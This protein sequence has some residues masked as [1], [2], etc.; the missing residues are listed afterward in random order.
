LQVLDRNY[1]TVPADQTEPGAVLPQKHPLVQYYAAFCKQKLGEGSARDWQAGSELSPSLVFP[2]SKTDRVVLE[3][4]LAANQSDATAHYLLGMLLFSKGLTDDGVAHWTEAKQLAPHLPV[5]DVEMGNFFL[6]LKGDPQR[7]L[8]SFREAMKNDPDNPVAYAGLDSALSMTGVSAQERADLLSQ[9]PSADAQDSKMPADLVYQLALTR[10]E[11]GQFERAAAPFKNRFFPSEEGGITSGEVLF[12][13]KLLQAES[14]AK[15]GNCTQA[16]EFI[17]GKQ[18]GMGMDGRTARDYV[19]LA[20][21]AKG[22]AQAKESEEFLHRAT[23]STERSDLVWADKAKVISGSRDARQADEQIANSLAAAE[24]H[25]ATGSHPGSWWFEIA[26]L[27]AAAHH[28]EQ[29]RQSFEQ[30]LAQPDTRMSHH[31]AREALA[32]LSAGK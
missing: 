22:C 21:I 11:A 13:I 15:A 2:S 24:K 16:G 4:A 27:Q 20:G 19:K 9:Y 26:Q 1:P 3:A 17:A 30:V 25:P 10:A 14:W 5:I 18:P 23:A 12:E 32:E 29:A 6:K 7:A 31:L 28:N 8:A